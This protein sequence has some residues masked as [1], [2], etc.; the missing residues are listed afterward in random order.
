MEN[1]IVLIKVGN[2]DESAVE[3][4]KVLTEYGKAIKVRLGL[5]DYD[6]ASSKGLIVLQV[7]KKEF[8]AEK[9]SKIEAISDTKVELIVI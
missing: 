8:G 4:Q 6:E 5:H 7:T 1:Y 3:V 2:R 9:K